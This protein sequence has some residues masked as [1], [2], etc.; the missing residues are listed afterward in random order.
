MADV[1]ISELT[2]LTSPSGGEELVVNDSGTTKKI[3]ITNATSASLPKAGGTMTGTITSTQTTALQLT[4]D[5]TN[6]I[7]FGDSANASIGKIEYVHSSNHLAFKVNDAERMRISADGNLGLGTVSPS[8]KLTSESAASTNIVAKST[9]GNGGYYNYQG[10]ASD[11]TQTFGVNHNG[12]I[13]TTSG[14]AVGGTEAANTLDEYEEGSFNP[15]IGGASTGGTP[16]YDDRHGRYTKVGRLVTYQIYIV[17]S[18][19]SGGAG[20][21]VVGGLPFTSAASIYNSATI[22]IDRALTL[23]ANNVV[24]AYVPVNSAVIAI[25]QYPAGGG[26]P[27]GVPIDTNCGLMI[28]GSYIV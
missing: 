7:N 23:S 17:W 16:T 11:G 12:T 19:L 3:T 9:N 21:L 28:Q 27:T 6:K 15:T 25:L 20:N 13:F 10:L 8:S 26:A 24:Q 18:A 14:L 1:K 22:F 4:N 5:T 2:A